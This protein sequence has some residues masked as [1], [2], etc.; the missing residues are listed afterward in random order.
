MTIEERIDRIESV[1]A[2]LQP[3]LGYF[4]LCVNQSLHPNRDHPHWEDGK[5]TDEV[6][7]SH[8][9]PS[10]CRCATD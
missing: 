5:D 4:G 8:G 6:G 9:L 10:R 1:L 7:I 2:Q 3:K